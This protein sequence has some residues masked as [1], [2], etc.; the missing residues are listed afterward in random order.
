LSAS[1]AQAWFI[2]GAIVAMV[3]GG[4]HV[5]GTLVDTVRPTFFTPIEGSAKAAAEGTTIQLGRMF[6]GDLAKRPSMW[7]IWLGIHLT[8][9]LGVFIFGLFCLVIATYDFELVELIDAIRPLTIAIS[10]AYFAISLRFFFYGPVIITGTATACFTIA[11]VL[12][13]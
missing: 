4:L 10:A 6:P 2:A 1:A 7:R 8:H 12:L 13:A 5:L 3:A 9:G 11:A